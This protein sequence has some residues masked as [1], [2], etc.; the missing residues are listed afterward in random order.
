MIIKNI[1]IRGES[2]RKTKDRGSAPMTPFHYISRGYRGETP[3][4]E[5][6][7]KMQSMYYKFK[8]RLFF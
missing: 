6:K 4:I 8:G 7:W 2:S 5:T 1:L 3:I